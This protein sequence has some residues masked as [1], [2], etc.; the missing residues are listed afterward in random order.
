[1]IK[2]SKEH[3]DIITKILHQHFADNE[4]WFFGSRI[5]GTAQKYADLDI[6][7]KITPEKL[8]KKNHLR[9]L[10]CLMTSMKATSHSKLMSSTGIKSPQNLENLFC[11]KPYLS[12][13]LL[14]CCEATNVRY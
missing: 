9:F 3:F 11:K 10:R 13:N 12:R 5:N 1:M 7:I 2:L 4:I 8:Q 6:L 14:S